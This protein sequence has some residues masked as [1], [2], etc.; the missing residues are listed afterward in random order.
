MT[1]EATG[2]R[3]TG[4]PAQR[5]GANADLVQG[6]QVQLEASVVTETGGII[7]ITEIET[8][9]DTIAAMA[10]THHQIGKLS[11]RIVRSFKGL[12]VFLIPIFTGILT[13]ATGV[14]GVQVLGTKSL[15]LMPRVR[16]VL[17]IDLDIANRR[18]S[19]IHYCQTVHL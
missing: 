15:K 19:R 11:W 7:K 14:I 17:C 3:A 12:V 5:Q 10:G 6:D 16:V 1:E 13:A 8:A 4:T 9:I 2:D 18:T